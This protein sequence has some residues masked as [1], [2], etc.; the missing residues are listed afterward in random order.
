[1]GLQMRRDASGEPRSSTRRTSFSNDEERRPGLGRSD[2]I[3]SDYS[4][5]KSGALVEESIPEMETPNTAKEEKIAMPPKEFTKVETPKVEAK[6]AVD[7]PSDLEG[8]KSNGHSNG[9]LKPKMAAEKVAASKTNSRLTPISTAK[10]AVAPKISPAKSPAKSPAVPRSP[11]TP[12]GR[13][14]TADQSSK[15]SEK[16]PEKKA[17]R[18]SL[19][20]THTSKPASRPPS[21]TASHTS[22]SK[23][24][25]HTSPPQTGFVKPKPR[26]P[27]RPVKLPA[28]LMAHTASSGSKTASAAPPPR[29]SLSRATGNSPSSN[30]L[31][32]HSSVVRSPSRT[33]TTSTSKTSTL[34]R[35]TSTLNKTST[36]GRPSLGPPPAALKKQSS[37]QSLAKS[38]PADDS[39]LNRM[40]RPTT[41]SASKTAAISPITPPKRASS[42]RRPAT[43]ETNHKAHE[44]P[45]ASPLVPNPV[46]RAAAAVTKPIAKPIAK[47]A[48]SVSQHVKKETEKK[49]EPVVGPVDIVKKAPEESTESIQEPVKIDESKVAEE[50]KS[51]ELAEATAVA[52]AEPIKDGSVAAPHVEDSKYE[53]SEAEI[54]IVPAPEIIEEDTL[55]ASSPVT[56]ETDI[57]EEPET[58]PEPFHQVLSPVVESPAQVHDPEI[59]GTSPSV[60][61]SKLS[62]TGDTTSEAMTEETSEAEVPAEIEDV[63]IEQP[64]VEEPDITLKSEPIEQDGVEEVEVEIPEAVSVKK[65][66]KN[67]AQPEKAEDPEDVRAR[68]EIARLNAE[69]MKSAAGETY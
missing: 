65:D 36:T 3:A 56:K 34:T 50:S 67:T 51:A 52:E 11:T 68:E 38:A 7:G 37:R 14:R 63:E 15:V 26:S 21:T 25:I 9:T 59:A 45:R 46:A 60:K 57:A 10:T 19:A 40:M 64:K 55:G 30:S 2:S 17:S 31:Q 32:G 33:S 39:F 49:A 62:V 66:E 61:T 20:P 43:R 5:K 1:M 16:K 35:K 53:E 48:A 47:A 41:S 23:T 42:V 4:R 69:L 22:T 27:T 13:G 6:K 12:R 58:I 18:S 24:K 28:S 54:T 29:R 44:A 8:T